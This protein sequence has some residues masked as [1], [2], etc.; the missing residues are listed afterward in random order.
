[1]N[2]DATTNTRA[3]T[4]GISAVIRNNRGEV[5]EALSKKIIGLLSPEDNRD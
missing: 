2:V 3:R 4:V 5:K 1:M